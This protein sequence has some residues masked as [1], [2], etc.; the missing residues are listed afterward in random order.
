MGEWLVPFAG[1]NESFSCTLNFLWQQDSLYIMD[2]HRVAAWCW[3]QHRTPGESFKVLHIDAHFDTAGAFGPSVE[4]QPKMATLS[5]EEY[6]GAHIV[7]AGAKICIYRWDNYISLL[8]YHH[9]ELV[10]HWMFATH[11]LGQEP[12]FAYTPVETDQLI[13][14]L[15]AMRTEGRP[16][17]LNLD[18]D[19]FR[20][21]EGDRFSAVDRMRVFGEIAILRASGQL[22]ATT[23][24][25]S[26][27][28]CGSWQAAEQL[29]EEL[30][31]AI[32]LSFSLP[33]AA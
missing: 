19:F 7:D 6:L 22:L 24:C 16:F 13:N 27:E 4:G 18:L 23:I 10:S 2:N 29:L 12:S 9:P 20:S 28:C 17:V 14:T 3:L 26:P 11:Q 1:R 15:K 33:G 21:M 5:L 31:T 32:G 25:L 8:Q 30:A